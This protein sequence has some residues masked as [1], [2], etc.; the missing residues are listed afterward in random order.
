MNF[1]LKLFHIA[2]TTMNLHTELN[3]SYLCIIYFIEKENVKLFGS[4]ENKYL[5]WTN[6]IMI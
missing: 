6:E 4:R 5:E 3:K 1:G 2:F